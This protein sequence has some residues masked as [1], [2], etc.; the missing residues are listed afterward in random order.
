MNSKSLD[1]NRLCN[2]TEE[3]VEQRLDGPEIRVI[4]SHIDAQ[5]TPCGYVQSEDAEAVRAIEA[6][7]ETALE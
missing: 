4:P 7:V 6:M 2:A 5:G 3:Y 1:F